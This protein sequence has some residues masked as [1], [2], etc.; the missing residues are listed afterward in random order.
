[1]KEEIKQKLVRLYESWADDKALLV[2]EMPISGSAREYCRIKGLKHTVLGVYNEDFKENRAFIEF[3]KHFR[4][5]GMKV[6][7][8]YTDDLI[9]NCYLI[10]DF[11]LVTLF[12]HLISTRLGDEF[13]EELIAIYKKILSDLVQ[14]QLYAGVDLDYSNC[15]P[16]AKFDKQSMLWDLHYFKYYFLKLAQISF[17]EQLLEDDY[18][19][20]ANYL[21]E[22]DTDYFMYR[23][24][25]SRNIMLIKGEP[26]YIDYQGG[27]KGALQYDLASLMYDAKANIPEQVREDL[28]EYYINILKKE[29][30]I[31]EVV[32]RKHYYGYVLV[33]IMQAMGA[34][35][36]RGF[37]EKKEHFLKSIPFAMENLKKVLKKVDLPIE[38]PQLMNALEQV[39]NSKK[40]LK[41]A[42]EAQVRLRVEI[43]SFSY[44]RG[45]PIDKS[46]NG[47]GFVF[48]CR[49]IHNP[50]RYVQYKELT[51]KDIEVISFF[52]KTN[53]MKDFLS[54]VKKLVA[55]SV[56]RYMKR[57]F[58]NLQVNFGCTG[59]QH[60]SVYAAEQ[61][62]KYLADTFDVKVVVRHIEREIVEK[63]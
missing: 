53:D 27:R 26:A 61:L 10:E 59:G 7:K 3:S 48:D 22:T 36:F 41:V 6:P 5:R 21:L 60:R 20:F 47:G 28:L 44:K 46:D 57:N 23:D 35:G 17:D 54:P 39:A 11:G 18:E 62:A 13:S 55:M 25:Q 42:E 1:M 29:K 49:A 51:G 34:Y 15:Y 38:V 14:F 40:L 8:I 58:S 24:F 45:I 43:N 16:R 52:E 63:G 37:Y 31:D 56:E 12:D 33:R 4:N 19:R 30:N 50:G 2:T 32:F 9:N